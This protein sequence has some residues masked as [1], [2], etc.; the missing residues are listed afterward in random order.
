ML[1]ALTGLVASNGFAQNEDNPFFSDLPIVA[2]VSRLPQRL[3]DASAA[4]TVIDRDMIKASGARDL[5]DVFR[6]VPGFMTYPNNTDA[7]RVTYHG[8]TNEDFSPRV[9][10]LIDGR[11]QYSPL[12]RNG[13]NWATLPVALEDVERIEVV[14]GTNAVS[15]GS[16]AFLGVINIITV[17]PAL[18]RG[19]SVSTNQGTQG[20]SDSTLRVGGRVGD[21]GDFRFTY[22]QKNDFGLTDQF[23]WKDSFDSRLLTLN[24]AYWLGNSEQLQLSLGHVEAVTRLGRLARIDVNGV[25]VLSGGEDPGNPFR[26]FDQSN[27]F[28]Q[29]GWRRILSAEAD[30]QLRYAYTQDRGSED[31]VELGSDLS[32]NGNRAL[33]Y[34]VDA[35]GDVGDRHEIEVQHTFAPTAATRVAW[36]AGYRLD[37]LQSDSYL[38]RHDTAYRRVGRIFGNVEWRPAEWFT[39]N[40][41][42]AGERDSLAGGNFSPRLSA[43]FH[44]TPEDT[45]RFGASRAFRTGSTADYIGV[46]LITP[47][48]TAGGVPIPPG[49][50]YRHKFLGDG[51]MAQE[52][53]DTVEI[54]YLGDW[55]AWRSSLDV[56][57]FHERVPN[58]MLTVERRLPLSVACDVPVYPGPCVAGAADFTTAVQRVAI[59]GLEFQWRWQPREGT[60]LQVGQAWT[61]ISSAFLDA[62]LAGG[63]TTLETAGNRDRISRLTRESAPDSAS[64]LLFMQRLPG[65]VDFSLAGYWVGNMKWTR[66]SSVDFYRRF[67]L[68]LGRPFNLAGQR[69]ELAYIAQSINGAHGE[70]KSSGEPSDRVVE[71]RQWVSLRLDF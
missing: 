4:V 55:K 9:Q 6:L 63:V 71:T 17:D 50:V 7:A 48:A 51:D 64:S 13:I 5:S 47:F 68:R 46:R 69:G 62:A 33:R 39:G 26:D 56:R 42:V 3:A 43:N 1:V 36:G 19:V 32:W 2:S 25:K 30:L 58:R 22:Q 67:D 70:F 38:P 45:L 54:G 15:Y 52:R 60:R 57:L 66:N 18:V 65:G 24:A 44:L 28:L 53:I 23:D 41:G 61:A 11:S 35:Y 49:Q 16:N 10:V 8:L 14:R 21:A 40:F 20:V 59:Q 12:F 29:L 34:R 31:H 27:T 37:S